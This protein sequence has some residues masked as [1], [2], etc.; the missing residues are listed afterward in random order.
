MPQSDAD[1]LIAAAF[2]SR[3]ELVRLLVSEPHLMKARTGLGETPLHYLAV[4]NQIDS[5]KILMEHGAEINTQNDF[6][7]APLSEAAGLGYADLVACLLD[8]GAQ[9]NLPGQKEPTLHE[10]VRSGSPEVVSLILSAGADIDEPNDLRETAVHVA[11][12]SDD[13]AAI[14]ELLLTAGGRTDLRRIFD[15]TPLDA[16]TSSGSERCAAVLRARGA[17]RSGDDAA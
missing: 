9:L 1:R 7:G 17:P 4:E 16:A 11:A 15:E 3:D 14:L 5:V 10:A 8:H 6:G 12:E 13:R 2:T